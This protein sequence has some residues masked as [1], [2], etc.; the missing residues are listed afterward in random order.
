MHFSG[1]HGK[2]VS[3]DRNDPK[4]QKAFNEFGFNTFASDQISLNRSI[5]DT[6]DPQFTEIFFLI[7]IFEIFY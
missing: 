3:I 6:R 7:K 4:V 5:P 1:A 2:A